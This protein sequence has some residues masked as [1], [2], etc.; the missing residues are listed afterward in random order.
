MN[1]SYSA[2]V[3]P[4]T[5]FEGLYNYVPPQAPAKHAKHKVR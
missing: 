3:L 2:D 1:G 5:P 4:V